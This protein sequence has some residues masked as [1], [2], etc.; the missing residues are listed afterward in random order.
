MLSIIKDIKI[1]KPQTVM[2][3]G[4]VLLTE[5]S[6]AYGVPDP[7]KTHWLLSERVDESQGSG[8]RAHKRRVETAGEM[9]RAPQ[10]RFH[11]NVYIQQRQLEE[12]SEASG[13]INSQQVWF[14]F[15][16]VMLLEFTVSKRKLQLNKTCF[17]IR[18]TPRCSG[19]TR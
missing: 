3:G 19:R 15:V 9:A 5:G 12:S 6:H 1:L 16:S 18:A 13:L 17:K 8:I 2:V 7:V 4:R 10:L 14:W 11:K